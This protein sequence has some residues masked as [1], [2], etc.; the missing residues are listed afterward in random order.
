[1]TRLTKEE[2]LE[3][4]EKNKT[5]I[6][7]CNVK[8]L[9]LFGSYA[10]DEQKENSDIDLLVEFSKYDIDNHLKLLNFLENK[11]NKK[12]DLVKPNII[13]EELKEDILGGTQHAAKI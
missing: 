7:N 4:I 10:R 8:S 2:I 11:F 9:I 5:F 3:T 13:R 12:V 6:K 1:M